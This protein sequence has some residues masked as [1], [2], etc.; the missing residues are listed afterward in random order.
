MTC[1][2]IDERGRCLN[3]R[4]LHCSGTGLIS[5]SCASP[6]RCG[7]DK[8]EGGFRCVSPTEDPCEGVDAFGG[9]R[10]NTATRCLQGIVESEPCACAQSCRVDAQT[11]E[12]RCF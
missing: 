7:W 3:G 12:A 8:Q 10:D 5:E 2:A 9:C 4:A 1:G 11:G 6:A